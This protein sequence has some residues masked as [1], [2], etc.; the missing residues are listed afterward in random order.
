MDKKIF[1]KVTFEDAEQIEQSHQ[2]HSLREM[3]EAMEENQNLF[4]IYKVFNPDLLSQLR[5][6]EAH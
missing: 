5:I 4:T 3:I 1:Q 6:E 2:R